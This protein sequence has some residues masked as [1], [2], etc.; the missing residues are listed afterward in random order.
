MRPGRKRSL[1]RVCTRHVR[2]V[3]RR[4]LSL[5]LPYG[6]ISGPPEPFIPGDPTVTSVEMGEVTGRC[7]AGA[8]PALAAWQSSQADTPAREPSRRRDMIDEQLA[9]LGIRTSG[10][11]LRRIRVFDVRL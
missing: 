4:R 5:T 8:T 11:P 1:P 2:G 3:R 9:Q 6:P 7:I 10:R